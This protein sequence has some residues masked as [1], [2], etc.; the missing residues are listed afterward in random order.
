MNPSSLVLGTLLALLVPGGSTL[1][2]DSALTSNRRGRVGLVNLVQFENIDCM[3]TSG[4]AGVC[5]TESECAAKGGTVEGNCAQ[6]F[7]SCCHLTFKKCGG[8]VVNNCT[9]IQNEDYPNAV[10]KAATCTWKVP[11]LN[12]DVCFIRLDFIKFEVFGAFVDGVNLGKCTLDQVSFVSGNGRPK[13]TLCGTLTGQHM[14]L[15]PGRGGEFSSI[16]AKLTTNLPLRKWNIKVTQVPCN[17]H[18]APPSHCEMYLTGISGNIKSYNFEGNPGFH[19]NDMNYNICFRQEEGM[20]QIAYTPTDELNS[21][22]FSTKTSFTMGRTG[23]TRCREDYLV[24]PGGHNGDNECT[25]SRRHV[26]GA[27]AG[28]NANEIVPTDSVD[29]FC[30]RRLNCV[31]KSATNSNIQTDV[32]PFKIRVVTSSMESNTPNQD[33][34]LSFTYRQIPC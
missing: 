21:F 3:T 28:Q 1:N 14:Y 16:T 10:R 30:G 11:K 29:R 23:Q 27:I 6:G 15:E 33:F 8:D 24:I 17:S 5:Y 2:P 22:R 13:P 32:K 26:E 31:F 20:C 18:S 9:H 19:L 25:T 34:G 12:N 4:Q 7:G